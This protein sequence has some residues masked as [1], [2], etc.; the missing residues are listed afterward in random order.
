MKTTRFLASVLAAVMTAVTAST[1]VMTALAAGPAS[2]TTG[3]YDIYNATGIDLDSAIVTP[4]LSLSR[5]EVPINKVNDN[6]VLTVELTV[7]GAD[8]QYA[9]TGLHISYDERLTLVPNKK[10]KCATLGPAGD[11]LM[12]G[13]RKGL[14]PN[15]FFVYSAAE[16]NYG[17]DG[18]LWSFQL[19]LPETVNVG[20]TFPIEILYRGENGNNDAFKNVEG[21]GQDI[22]DKMEAWVFTK[23]I[24]QGYIKITEA[25]EEVETVENIETIEEVK[26]TDKHLGDIDGDNKV[27]SSDATNI[28]GAFSA[29]STGSETGLTEEQLIRADVNND[30]K[31]DSKDA[32]SVLGYYGYTS[33]GGTA[34]IDEYV[35]LN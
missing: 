23:G 4:T 18:V 15:D 1:M 35:T 19:Q 11:S 12:A 5:I 21:H 30:K 27:N 8:E 3:E 24:E 2:G 7:S 9:S 22:C 33:T 28:L 31:V 25:V 14:Y 29:L 16:G 34:S 6:R 32:T 10:G 20:D 17:Y 26:K 13:S